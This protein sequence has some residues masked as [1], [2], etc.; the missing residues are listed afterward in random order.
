MN[1]THLHLALN[2][3]PVLGVPF[4]VLLLAWGWVF[5]QREVVRV[6]VLW[7]ALLSVVAIAV[8]FTGDFAVDVDPKRLSE[9]R[10]YVDRHEESADQATTAVFLLGL[11]AAVALYLGR[12]ERVLPA[13]ML[14][15]LVAL[16][17]GTSGL[18]AR[19]AN[20]GGQINHPELRSSGSK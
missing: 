19:S 14:A 10:A 11:A 12:G 3:L 20:L 9:V 16:G 18:Y 1:W 5:R 4:V 15:V 8:K 6:A 7:M 13:W 2:H 17:I